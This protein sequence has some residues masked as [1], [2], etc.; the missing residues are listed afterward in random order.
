MAAPTSTAPAAREIDVDA[1]PIGQVGRRACSVGIKVMRAGDSRRSSMPATA[2]A[3]EKAMIVLVY[4]TRPSRFSSS[5][6]KQRPKQ[7]PTGMPSPIS[8][9]PAC[10]T[11]R[12]ALRIAGERDRQE[13]RR[14][15][16]RAAAVDRQGRPARADPRRSVDRRSGRTDSDFAFRTTKDWPCRPSSNHGQQKTGASLGLTPV[17]WF[18]DRRTWFL[19]KT[20]VGSIRPRPRGR[21]AWGLRSRCRTE[22]SQATRGCSSDIGA[23]G[24]IKNGRNVAK[25][26]QS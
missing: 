20:R 14:R 21:G 4:L 1:R 6:R 7:S 26:H 2:P 12:R 23:R 22:P 11:A 18:W 8:R 3:S 24:R 16:R 9:P 19:A 5:G 17:Q 15:L 10:G 13:G 25:Y